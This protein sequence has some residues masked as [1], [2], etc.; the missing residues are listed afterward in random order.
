MGVGHRGGGVGGWEDSDSG[1]RE[2]SHTAKSFQLEQKTHNGYG[3][4]PG[5]EPLEQ[6]TLAVR[7]R[8]S[9]FVG[10]ENEKICPAK[11]GKNIQ[12]GLVS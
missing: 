11:A 8:Y 5:N 3:K 7:K 2:S 12:E 9:V 6:R 10:G 1:R 4:K